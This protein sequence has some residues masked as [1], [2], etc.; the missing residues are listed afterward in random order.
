[1]GMERSAGRLQVD[2]RRFLG[3]GRTLCDTVL[4]DDRYMFLYIC[5]KSQNVQC[6][7]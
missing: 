5:P 7:E 3:Q 2:H 1:M 4:C 6:Q